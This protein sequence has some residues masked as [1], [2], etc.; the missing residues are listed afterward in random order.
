[1]KKKEF[2]E[3]VLHCSNCGEVFSKN[4]PKG[5]PFHESFWGSSAGYGVSEYYK[6]VI[7]CPY[8]GCYTGIT[9]REN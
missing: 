1:M 6:E 9:K 3:L 8:C 4:I 7:D 5:Q 2:Y